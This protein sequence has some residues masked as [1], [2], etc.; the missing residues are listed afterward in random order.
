[1]L[2]ENVQLTSIVIQ[3]QAKD[4][5]QHQKIPEIIKSIFDISQVKL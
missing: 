2:V 1:M 3:V 4:T 5:I